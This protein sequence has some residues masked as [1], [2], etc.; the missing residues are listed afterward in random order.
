MRAELEVAG[1]L[2]VVC[3]KALTACLALTCFPANI[4]HFST[5]LVSLL[6]FNLKALFSCVVAVYIKSRCCFT[7]SEEYNMLSCAEFI[8]HAFEVGVRSFPECSNLR[9]LGSIF[10][11][12]QDI[13]QPSKK[14]CYNVAISTN[15]NYVASCYFC[16]T[17]KLAKLV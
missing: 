3:R 17:F 8:C 12:M 4:S 2:F 16:N 9:S 15:L 13:F 11:C 14:K 5:K 1:G 10:L 6:R 7:V